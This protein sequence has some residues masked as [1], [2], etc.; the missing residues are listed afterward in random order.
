MRNKIKSP[1]S[2]WT[3]GTKLKELHY[4]SSKRAAE[5]LSIKL[6]KKHNVFLRTIKH[7]KL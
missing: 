7:N 3:K 2:S 5:T 1:K 4:L 6:Y